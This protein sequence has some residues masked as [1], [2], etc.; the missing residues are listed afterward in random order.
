MAIG[1]NPSDIIEF[2]ADRKC[3]D[4]RY[5][6]DHA[7]LTALGWSP[8][9]TWKDGIQRTVDWYREHLSYWGDIS[10]ALVPHPQHPATITASTLEEI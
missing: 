2:V 8:S 9:I 5:L 7:N 3:Q 4:N 6:I 1:K 10:A